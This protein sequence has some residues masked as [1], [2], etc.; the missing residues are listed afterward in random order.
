MTSFEFAGEHINAWVSKFDWPRQ[1]AVSAIAAA[2]PGLPLLIA[3]V[4][5]AEPG[6][7][8]G[9][10][11]GCLAPK[12]A[13][14]LRQPALPTPMRNIVA[15]VADIAMLVLAARFCTIPGM[16]Q[17]GLGDAMTGLSAL[18]AAFAW[19]ARTQSDP[20]SRSL[21]ANR[22]AA[23]NHEL[24]TPL[25]AVAG[26]AGLM[27]NLPEPRLTPARCQ[28]YARIIE[29]SAEHMLAILEAASGSAPVAVREPQDI[30]DIVAESLELAAPLAAVKAVTLT[31]RQPARPVQAI[32]DRH[33][34][35]Q[36]LLNFVSNAVKFSPAGSTVEVSVR[37]QSGGQ[38]E[39]AVADEGM[40]IANA[41][42]PGLGRPFQRGAAAISQR[43]DGSGLGLAI[44]RRLAERQGG[45]LAFDSSPGC[46]T[47]ARLRLAEHNPRGLP[48]RPLGPQMRQ[49]VQSGTAVNPAFAIGSP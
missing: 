24:R 13:V 30:D 6:P 9:L 42:L 32:G 45:K 37:R 49:A 36:I 27:R 20:A 34:L 31:Y 5:S 19:Y 15:T 22:L 23:L 29:T 18:L 21:D 14:S 39:I 33:A 16:F 43:I 46:G 7:W 8:L 26:F 28:D 4:V 47:T 17:A 48:S 38:I 40:G 2:A 10:A 44:S 11:L 3:A 25:N 1:T 35:R 12:L 41:E